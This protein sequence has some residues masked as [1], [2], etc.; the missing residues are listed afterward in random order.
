MT[1]RDL[2]EQRGDVHH[3]FP[4]DYLIKSGI[5]VQQRYNQI[6]N[7]TYLQQEIN[8]SISNKAPSEYFKIL[9]KQVSGGRVIYGGITNK[10]DLI[11]NLNE[12]AIPLDVENMT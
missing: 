2:I 9:N 12:N 7:Y 4:K 3:I 11:D 10:K 6:A 5:E 1:V 8:I